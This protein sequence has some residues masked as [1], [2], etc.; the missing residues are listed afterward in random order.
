MSWSAISWGSTPDLRPIDTNLAIASVN[1]ATSLP[2]LPIWA[3]NSTGCPSKAFSVRNSLPR[4]VSLAVV[5]PSKVAGR[6]MG[7]IRPH[8]PFTLPFLP[9]PK[10]ASPS[11]G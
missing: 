3:N 10:P 4:G 9:G 2:A 11:S 6:S 8:T 1:A 5:N 7:L